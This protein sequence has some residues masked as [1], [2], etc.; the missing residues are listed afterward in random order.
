MTRLKEVIR[1]E[2]Q[3]AISVMQKQGVKLLTP[4]EAQIAD[5]KAISE[6]AMQKQT[7]HKYSLKT[8]EEASSWLKAFA[9]G[10]K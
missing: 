9:E 10:R 7:G 4:G 1:A 8:K 2:N 5:Y 6:K 3:E